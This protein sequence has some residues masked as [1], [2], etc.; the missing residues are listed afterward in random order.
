MRIG[1]FVFILTA[2]CGVSVAAEFDEFKVKREAVFEFSETPAV[3]RENGKVVIT[4]A[5]KGFCDATVAIED[6]KGRIV[7]HLASGVLGPNA[8]GPFQKNSKRQRLVWDE[9]DDR[10]RAISRSAGLSVR[11]SLGLKPR[12]ERTLYWEPKRRVGGG[13]PIIA[14][15]KEGVYVFDGSMVDNLRLY[16]HKGDYVKTVYPFPASKLGEVQGLNWT[17]FPQLAEK[18]PLKYGTFK[19]TLLTS[20]STRFKYIWA[21]DA[22][23]V[24]GKRIALARLKLNRLAADGTSGGLGLGG[25]VTS[26]E[27]GKRT[28]VTPRDAALS[29][30]GR[31]LYLA[32]YYQRKEAKAPL[33]CLPCVLKMDYE[34]DAEPV[35]FA[36]KKQAGK[37]GTG[38]KELGAAVSVACDAGGRVF[39]ADYLNDRVQVYSPE[40]RHLKSIAATRPACVRVH[41]R[42]GEVYVFSWM[43]HPTLD[44][45]KEVKPTLTR[46]GP[47]EKPARLAEYALPGVNAAWPDKYSKSA[48]DH[49][50]AEIDSWTEPPAIWLSRE[51]LSYSNTTWEN[52]GTLLMVPEGGKLVVKRDF[53]KDA[54]ETVDHLP[55][56]KALSQYCYVNPRTGRLLLG[57]C[58]GRGTYSQR[59]VK[60]LI[61]IDPEAGKHR[62]VKLPFK[63]ADLAFDLDGIAHMRV[64]HVLMRYDLEKGAPLAWKHGKEFRISGRGGR[65]TVKSGLFCPPGNRFSWQPGLSV[66]PSGHVAA[67]VKVGKYAGQSFENVMKPYP[68]RPNPQFHLVIWDSSGKVVNDDALPGIDFPNGLG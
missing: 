38:P 9:K 47:F 26:F 66:S 29:P 28:P 68:G 65:G 36:G 67:C 17:K 54:L 44:G 49:Y 42:T 52:T 14:A 48:G 12:F 2:V 53:A 37:G 32:G 30:D 11:V 50:R 51:H 4:F 20:G 25:P 43:I 22:M 58:H 59:F 27:P 1:R 39:V 41:A 56:A 33:E 5:S 15:A 24:R 13:S 64:D 34:S 60:H 18:L 63:V 62:L 21:A 57:E 8:P 55:P 23:A 45:A 6:A 19:T 31:R 3:A 46:F 16:D 7:R 61:E 40:G 35:V 10:G